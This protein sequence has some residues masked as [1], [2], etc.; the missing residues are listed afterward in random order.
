LSET[1]MTEAGGCTASV[2]GNVT[3]STDHAKFISVRVDN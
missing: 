1:G 3:V 2:P